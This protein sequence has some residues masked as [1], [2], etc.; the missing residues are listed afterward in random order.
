MKIALIGYGKMGKA[1]QAA[2]ERKNHN[3]VCFIDSPQDW[4]KQC[5][6]LGAIA[7]VAI[8]FSTPESAVDNIK[9]CFNEHIPVVCGSTGWHHR[10]DEIKTC[11]KEK[12][13][14]LVWA[15]NFS[16]GVNLFFLLN[17][18]LARQMDKFTQYD[19]SIEEIHHTEKRDKPS[20]TAIHLANQ[21]IDKITRLERWVK[22]EEAGEDLSEIPVFSERIKNV[23]GIHTVTYESDLDV[24]EIRHTAKNR[25]GFA[26]GALI[27]AEWINNKQKKGIFTM[28]DVL[29]NSF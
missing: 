16:P 10:M 28:D 22:A 15:A 21:M 20:G 18:W 25:T 2:A 17:T 7:D 24:I 4:E 6:P 8:E 14:T 23:T 11:C 29:F 3:V 26:F 5:K 9:R 13:G 27:A 12:E 19:A 1:L